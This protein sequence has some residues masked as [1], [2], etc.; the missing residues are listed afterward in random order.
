ME[1]G[2]V[3]QY[4]GAAPRHP[5]QLLQGPILEGKFRLYMAEVKFALDMPKDLKSPEAA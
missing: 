1:S 4:E 3:F 2:T 5:I